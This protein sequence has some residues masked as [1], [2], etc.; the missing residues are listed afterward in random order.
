MSLMRRTDPGASL[1]QDFEA[2]RRRM[3]TLFE[4]QDLFD[5]STMDWM[6]AVDVSETDG[7]YRIQMALPDVKKEDVKIA[8]ENG[9]LTI[10]GERKHRKEERNE[11]RIRTEMEYGS[12]LRSFTM[13][14]DVDAEKV[15]ARYHD[16]M[17]DLTIA[18]AAAKKTQSRT[19]AVQ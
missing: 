11:R 18:K 6:P 14:T 1:W 5:T 16:G 3:L 2:M 10:R 7:D 12:F 15:V 19:I 8:L 17:L 4:G 9:M 13:P